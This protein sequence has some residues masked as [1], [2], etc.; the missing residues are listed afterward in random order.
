[1]LCEN[2]VWD[3]MV[4]HAPLLVGT[5]VSTNPL[6]I[7][8]TGDVTTPD[9]QINSTKSLISLGPNQAGPHGLVFGDDA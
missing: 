4:S 8:G 5:T 2:G 7:Q 9:I 6:T 1:M 3:V